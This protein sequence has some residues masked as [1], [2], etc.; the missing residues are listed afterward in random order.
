MRDDTYQAVLLEFRADIFQ[1]LTFIIAVFC[2]AA[3]ILLVSVE[4]LPHQFILTLQIFGAFVFYI[5]HIAAHHPATARYLFVTALYVMMGVGML[6]LRVPWLPFVVAPLLFVSELL[7]AHLSI[8]AGALFLGFAGVLVHTGYAD[9]PVQ[10]LTLFTIFVVVLSRSSL[11][12]IWVLLQWYYYMFGKSSALL[13]ETRAHRAELLQ[14]LKS[15]EIARETQQRLQTQLVYAQRQAEEARAMKERFASNISHELR[16]PL[17]IIVGFTEIMHLTPE[18][19]GAVS[20][21]PKLQQ[22][23][24][25]IHRNS[26]HLLD[27]IDDVLDLSHIEM[28]QFSLNFERTDLT[29][30]LRDTTDLLSHL[31]KGKPVEFIVHI[32]D[33]LPEIQIDRTRIRQVIINLLNNAQ[34]FTP[35]GSVTFAVRADERD[36]IFQVADT[37]I[38]IPQ[39]QMQLIFEEFFQVDY[40]LSRSTGGAGLGL[41]ITRRFVE[42]HNGHLRA[43]SKEGVGSTFTFTLPLPTLARSTRPAKKPD[44]VSRESLWL[45]IDADPYVGKLVD[46]HVGGGSIVQLENLQQLDGALRRYS[47]QGIIFNNPFDAAI[48]ACLDDAPVPVVICSLPSTAQMVTR[49]GVDACLAKPILPHQLIEH[50]EA[51]QP[52]KSVLV[53][54]DDVGVVQLVQRTLENRFPDLTIGRAYNG[55]QAGEMMNAAPPDL[56]LLDLVMPTMSGFEVI[57]SIKANE[58][59]RDIPVILLTATKY[60]QSDEETRGDLR[61]HRDGGLKPTEVLRL[62]DMITQSVNT[63]SG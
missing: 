41:A 60:I 30:F 10:A 28:T 48:P 15:L 32:P 52:L 22:D 51:Y 54:D 37:G 33:D 53:I 63:W 50:I 56:I 35:Q 6:I 59:L 26:R 24:Y 34:R 11:R 31:F 45:V 14:T 42:A 46:R 19:Y 9:Y 23:I 21:P 27:M 12:A 47:P 1:R 43:E 8:L 62:L 3:G 20:F 7:I 36:V 29:R 57:A 44:A 18:V 5:R 49:L 25:Q 58:R 38:G 55:L 17:N 39:E 40:S 16:T 2:I 61:I 4:P 13:E